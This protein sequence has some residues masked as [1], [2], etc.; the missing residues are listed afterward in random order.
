V[1]TDLQDNFSALFSL[2][3]L[4]A[5]VSTPVD[6]RVLEVNDAFLRLT[7]YTRDEVMGRTSEELRL[8]VFPDQRRAVVQGVLAGRQADG[9][10]TRLRTRSGAERSVQV[11]VSRARMNG[12]DALL[13]IIQDVTERQAVEEALRRSEAR[14]LG[15]TSNLPGAVFQFEVDAA[16]RHAITYIS[17]GAEAIFE[18]PVASLL[19]DPRLGNEVHPEDRERFIRSI[20]HAVAACGPWHCDFRVVLP[21]GRIKWLHAASKPSHL[22][23]RQAMIW[24]GVILEFTDRMLA[25]AALDTT[26]KR[27]QALLRHL[28][29]VIMVF[30]R[31]A[32]HL[33]VSQ[34][35]REATGMDPAA[36]IGKTHAE[37]GFPPDLCRFWEERIQEVFES[38][39]PQETDFE[40]PLPQGTTV[41]NWRLIPLPGPD[42]VE[43]VLTMARDVTATR[44]AARQYEMLFQEMLD[45]F[46]LHEILCDDTGQPVDYRFLSVNPAFERLTGLKA[47]DILSRRVLEVMPN[48]EPYWIETYGRVAL[49]GEPI[50]FENYSRVLDRHF[51]VRAFRP[52]PGRFA[53]LFSD[54]TDRKRAE[55]I[56]DVRHRISLAASS[57]A[58]AD[59]ILRQ[60]LDG[61][62]ELPGV[63]AGCVY[64]FDERRRTLA[65]ACH[66]GLSPAFVEA[67]SFYGPDTPQ[68]ALIRT[69]EPVV[70]HFDR[71]RD[72]LDPVCMKEGLQALAIL[73]LVYKG[74]ILG[75]LNVASK[76]RPA[77]AEETLMALKAVVSEMAA[78]V[79]RAR[80]EEDLHRALEAAQAASRAKSTF[81]TTMSHEVRTPLN[82]ILGFTEL[83]LG[84]PLTDEQRYFLDIVKGRSQDL[85][86]ILNDILDLSRIEADKLE[87][88]AKPFDLRGLVEG[89]SRL[90]AVETEKK[91]LE[92]S[93]E[94]EPGIPASV[95]GDALRF[96]QV[97][98]NLVGNAVKF[99][100]RGRI[101]IAVASA[102]GEQPLE[103]LRLLVTVT[104]TGIGIPPDKRQA[105]FEPFIQADGSST[106]R[107][108][109]A[110][111]GLAV[112]QRLVALMGGTIWCESEPGRGSRFFFTVVCGLPGPAAAPEPVPAAGPV[113]HPAP[114][115]RLAILVVD[116]DDASRI[117]ARRILNT[118]GH[119]AVF[120]VDGAEALEKLAE[121]DFDVVFMDVRMPVL[122]GLEATRRIRDPASAVRRH[123]VP[124]IA[125]TAN[126]MKGD[127][128]ECLAAGM[129]AYMAKPV[130]ADAMRAAL[131]QVLPG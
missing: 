13:A 50:S 14:L 116:D 72:I 38:G 60:V 63:D 131:A 33:F 27:Y 24:S 57:S 108:G 121:R 107:Y 96:K 67:V 30:D 35:V 75:V 31:Q 118:I 126:A 10:I 103:G 106:R 129:T 71:I 130:S 12:Q 17:E 2:L 64:H 4:A 77:F 86:G 34:S 101:A 123:D 127:D 90:F 110:G 48:T 115:R 29:D 19:G 68:V 23:D 88:T 104:D 73:P 58:D 85:L 92:L 39:K 32:R 91:N 36:F 122:D 42:N 93:Y 7:G 15:V 95:V 61:L 16:G 94:V 114:P 113:R 105:I 79:H 117:L 69:G 76:S 54:I 1:V 25:E 49:T 109:G 41:F 53:C 89:V 28:P 119:D 112:A 82:G 43:S 111:L 59:Y 65:A 22:P 87:L 46:A 98:I 47:A 11:W 26:E 80:T 6:G 81:L 128:A 62:C 70:G 124:V 20:E 9:V 100:D 84:T 78:A 21:D 120:A 3:P 18:K 56:L 8:W 99:T 5:T 125:M 37:L 44:R 66:R 83:A 74:R 97:L 40:V 52:E 55:L 51:H 45:G 102:P